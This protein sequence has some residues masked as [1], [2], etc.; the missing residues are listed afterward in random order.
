VDWP[1][2]SPDGTSLV[3]STAEGLVRWNIAGGGGSTPIGPPDVRPISFSPD[4]HLLAVFRDTAPKAVEL[5]D[6]ATGDL[7]SRP[8]PL[9]RDTLGVALSPDWRK[10]AADFY[11]YQ[12]VYVWALT[13]DPIPVRSRRYRKVSG[14]LEGVSAMAFSPD[15]KLLA[16]ARDDG[17]IEIADSDTGRIQGRSIAGRPDHVMSVGFDSTGNTLVSSGPAG[18]YLWDVRT[19]LGIGKGLPGDVAVFDPQGERLITF[20]P[21]TGTGSV[22][23]LAPQNMVAHACQVAGRNLDRGEWEQLVPD[24]PYRKVCPTLP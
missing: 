21:E 18:T 1:I 15:G 22:W 11:K 20:D 16:V 4:G 10:M 2:L 5:L 14:V 17:R 19:Q 12:S 23:D 13:R 6:P 3:A 8:F 9:P 24:L 7:A